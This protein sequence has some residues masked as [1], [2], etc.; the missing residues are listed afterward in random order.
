MTHPSPRPRAQTAPS[1]TARMTDTRLTGYTSSL[2]SRGIRLRMLP[3]SG[4]TSSTL[5]ARPSLR[6]IHTD[7]NPAANPARIPSAEMLF[8]CRT[9]SFVSGS[10]PVSVPPSSSTSQTRSSP[11]AISRELNPTSISRT[12]S[13]ATGSTTPTDPGWTC[14]PPDPRERKAVTPPARATAARPPA[15]ATMTARREKRRDGGG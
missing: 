14:V 7:S 3:S 15:P 9:T 10:I 2:S 6:A 12:T 1:P 4:S 13:R 5:R 8:L 11:A